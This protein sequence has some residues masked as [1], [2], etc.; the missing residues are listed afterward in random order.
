MSVMCVM[1]FVIILATVALTVTAAAHQN[2]VYQNNIQQAYFTAKSAADRTQSYISSIG[3]PSSSADEGTLRKELYD[4]SQDLTSHI[5]GNLQHSTIGDYQVDIYPTTNPNV[6]KVVASSKWKEITSSAAIL[7]GPTSGG[8]SYDDAIVGTGGPAALEGSPQVGGGMTLN[9]PDMSKSSNG[10][11]YIGGTVTNTGSLNFGD[12]QHAYLTSYFQSH[13]NS[14][15]SMIASGDIANTGKLSVG[16]IYTVSSVTSNDNDQDVWQYYSYLVCKDEFK[17]KDWDGWDNNET[18]RVRFAAAVSGD[19]KAILCGGNFVSVSSKIAEIHAPVYIGGGIDLQNVNDSQ[20]G[21][22]FKEPVYIDCNGTNPRIQIKGN[23]T[24]EKGLYIRRTDLVSNGDI[25]DKSGQ[26]VHNA[27]YI[28]YGDDPAF[29][30]YNALLNQKLLIPQQRVNMYSDYEF[31]DDQ[32]AAM[33]M[34]GNQNTANEYKITVAPDPS[35]NQV[36]SCLKTYK[37]GALQS[38]QSNGTYENNDITISE[39]GYISQ[40]NLVGCKSDDAVTI[41][42]DTRTAENNVYKDI[43]LRLTTTDCENKDNMRGCKFYVRGKGNVYFFLDGDLKFRAHQLPIKS[44]DDRYQPHFWIISNSTQKNLGYAN[45]TIYFDDGT[46]TSQNDDARNEF[47][48]Y[49]PGTVIQFDGSTG[50]YGFM[51]GYSVRCASGSGVAL[52]YVQP[53]NADGTENNAYSQGSNVTYG[54]LLRLR[55]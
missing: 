37:S 43:Y 3:G 55:S 4:I 17:I 19:E 11:V 10:D 20:H 47:Y 40:F 52:T 53:K 33:G 21:I 13:R 31:T 51:V 24:F 38:S 8:A 45:A 36:I 5:E 30:T 35:S 16:R 28:H 46:S 54:T 25:L 18:K 41:Y 49:A 29:E 2:V 6:F 7:V 15:L 26:D 27:S 50:F 9:M 12:N 42:F 14:S 22:V 32:R 34:D 23:V 48:I 39:S 44:I 1:S